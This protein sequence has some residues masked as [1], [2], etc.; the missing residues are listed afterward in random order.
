M[1]VFKSPQSSNVA[2]AR[3]DPVSK[4]M[5]IDFRSGHTYSYSKVPPMIWNK[6]SLAMSKGTFM[7]K[8]IRPRYKGIKMERTHA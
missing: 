5:Q 2:A 6:F 8:Y 4:E 1:R 3:Y 7:A